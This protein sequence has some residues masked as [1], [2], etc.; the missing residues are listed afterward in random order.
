[1]YMYLCII[2]VHLHKNIKA[3][4]LRIKEAIKSQ[5]YTVQGV[6][7]KIGKS[8]QSLHGIIEKGNPTI[9]TLSDIAGAIGVSISELYEEPKPNSKLTCPHCGKPITIKLE[10][11]EI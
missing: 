9:N 4:K 1:M 6:A 11:P 2:R 5:G 7:E 3:M 8:K 10:K